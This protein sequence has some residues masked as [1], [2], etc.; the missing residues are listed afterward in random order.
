M[1]NDLKYVWQDDD[2]TIISPKQW[3]ENRGYNPNRDPKTGRFTFGDG[4]HGFDEKGFAQEGEV[5]GDVLTVSDGTENHQYTLNKK[6]KE[7]MTRELARV[8]VRYYDETKTGRD[9]LNGFYRHSDVRME[10][11]ANNDNKRG[12]FYHEM[13]HAIDYNYRMGQKQ[14]DI[15]FSGIRKGNP[16]YNDKQFIIRNRLSDV[17]MEKTTMSYE[18]VI[19]MSDKNW[20]SIKKGGFTGVDLPNGERKAFYFMKSTLTYPSDNDEV[21]AD[22]YRVFRTEPK[23]LQKYAP[24]AYKL[25][26]ELTS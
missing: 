3:A 9:D 16:L 10:L 2:I 5:D 20:A 7:I 22:G 18:D 1:N 13:G 24:N 15:H 17:L 26:E 11:N 8:K 12:T 19:N 4:S 25:Y 23:K 21:F 6:E 14:S